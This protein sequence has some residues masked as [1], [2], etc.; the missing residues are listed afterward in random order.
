MATTVMEKAL[1]SS[2][3]ATILRARSLRD[4]RQTELAELF[5]SLPAGT[6]PR[7]HLEGS[8]FALRGT[9]GL[10][11]PLKRLL[12]AL[13]AT[14]LN[15]WRG[16]AF[17]NNSGSN[18]WLW[19]RG[20]GF[21]HFLCSEQAGPDGGSSHWLDYNVG[22]N[23]SLLRNIRGEARQ[24]QDG[25]WLCRMLWQRRDGDLSTLLWFVLRERS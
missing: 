16:K 2:T 5:S 3:P 23:P 6:A 20:P 4:W 7:G 24:L 11:A 21:G 8:L 9:H 13:L 22:R 12:A 18:Q 1:M 14:P 19:L 17:A 15:P 10:P 25:A